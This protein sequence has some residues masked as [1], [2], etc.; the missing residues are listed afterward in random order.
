MEYLIS[1]KCSGKAL[2]LLKDLFTYLHIWSL[3]TPVEYKVLPYFKHVLHVLWCF[4][5]E[6]V[7][8]QFSLSMMNLELKMGNNH[9]GERGNEHLQKYYSDGKE[10]T[11]KI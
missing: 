8:D 2:L 5:L 7:I 11:K 3:C 6:A 4:K 1:Q 10:C 9:C